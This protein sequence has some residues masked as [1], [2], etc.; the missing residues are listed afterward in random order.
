MSLYRVERRGGLRGELRVPGDK[1]ISHRALLLNGVAHG[2]ARV[3]GLLDAGDVRSTARCLRLLG[4]SIERDG[5]D[6][7]VE[8]RAM[9]L[10]EPQD[11]LDCG[12]SGTSIRLLSGVLAGQPFL[13]VLTGDASLRG[14][15]MRRVLDPLRSMGARVDGRGEGSLAPL[16][17]RGGGLQNRA[18]TLPIASAQVKSALLLAGLQGEGELDLR[19]D[20][21]RDHTERM[22]LA[23]G[24]PLQIDAGGLRLLGRVVPESVDVDVPGDISSAAFFLVAATIVPD[25]E[26]MLRDVGLNPTRDGIIEVLRRMGADIRIEDRIEVAGEARGTLIVRSA[27]LRGVTIEAALVPRLIDELPVLAVAA[28]MAEGE[29]IVMG[30]GELRVK[31]SDRI[32]ATVSLLRAL[33]AEAD[34]RPD[35]FVVRGGGFRSG[36]QIDA[37]Q[38]HRIAMAGAVAGLVAP[39]PTYIDGFEAVGISFPTFPNLLASLQAAGAGPRHR[40]PHRAPRPLTIA[41]DG[42]ASSGKGTV[43]RAVARALGYAYID[44]GAMYRTVAL[45]AEENGVPWTDASALGTLTASID[46]RFRWDGDAL[47]V[48][49][50][51]RDVTEV[52]RAEHIGKGASAVAVLP[53]VR[54]ALLG[55]QRALGEAGGVVMDGRDIGTVVLPDAELKIFLDAR[56]EERARRRHAELVARGVAVELPTVLAEIRERDERDSQRATAPLKKA[57]DAEV[58]D[59]TGRTVAEVV[60]RALELARARGAIAP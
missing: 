42:P 12:N 28:A 50:G 9:R 24:V 40:A 16:A 10:L 25:S 37:D 26:V 14:R 44:S 54:S 27:A 34:E 3:G 55:R 1:S 43:A 11:V 33:G 31:E 2:H 20:V 13:S 56:P 47:R 45:L 30:A 39:G 4:V 36:G 57:D 19:V 48:S 46:F 41:I 32:R 52:L 8:G 53:A 5:G 60:D 17:I 15:P 49:V 18:H 38:D 35:G 22:L 29:T 7:V 51:E 58:V 59:S 21:C 23:M 6:V